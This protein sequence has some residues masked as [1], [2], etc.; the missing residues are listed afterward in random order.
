MYVYVLHTIYCI[1]Y[2]VCDVS[3]PIR[4]V[5]RN[6]TQITISNC[7]RFDWAA[8]TVVKLSMVMG[9][10]TVTRY[11]RCARWIN[12]LS[13]VPLPSHLSLTLV[14]KCKSESLIE[15]YKLDCLQ[16]ICMCGLAQSGIVCIWLVITVVFF[17]T[18]KNG[19]ATAVTL[20]HIHIV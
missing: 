16:F 1:S 7:C 15:T 19:I 3:A 12:S 18:R 17:Q 13:I 9:V 2:I 5:N 11:L 8:T 10:G 14:S 20:L 4:L 6:Q